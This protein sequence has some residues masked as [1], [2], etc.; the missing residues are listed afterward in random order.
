[1]VRGDEDRLVQA[2]S[3]LVENALACVPH[4]G[5]VAVETR[6]G[7]IVVR[8]NGP[9]LSADDLPHAFERF[10]LHGRLGRGHGFGSGLGL[11]IVWELVEKMGGEISVTSELGKGTVFSLR[12]VST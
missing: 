8:D 12:L 7:E 6:S 4:G 1:M 9:G 5:V 2:V 3:N 11:A 10:Y